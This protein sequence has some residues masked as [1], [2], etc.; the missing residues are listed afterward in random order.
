MRRALHL[1]VSLVPLAFVGACFTYIDGPGAADEPG[2]PLPW[3]LTPDAAVGLASASAL[4]LDARPDDLRAQEPVSRARVLS[5]Q[6]LSEPD[7]PRRGMLLEDL[8]ALSG[9][10]RGV[11]VSQNQDVIVLGD[12]LRG[13]GEAGRIV[14]SLRVM[15]HERAALVD[16]GAP[17]FIARGGRDEVAEP[18]VAPGDFVARPVPA[19][20][21]DG[22]ALQ[23][24][25]TGQGSE[26]VLLD[27]RERREFDGQT[28][29]GE[30]RGGHVPGA[31]HLYFKELLDDDG[32]LLE[33][34]RVAAL[35][36][37]RGVSADDDIVAYCTGGVRSAFV[38]AALLHLGYPNVRNYP[39]SM[40]EW[41]AQD[42][43]LD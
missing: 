2:E 23:A 19:L 20:G 15:G 36:S 32:F 29:Y 34:E 4:V 35:L 18:G 8:D 33:P 7:D 31:V 43:P 30:S 37:A 1:F 3:I 25:L 14:W 5:W 22:P 41:S 11:G 12:P 27:T 39:A 9:V 38:V 42:W 24:A 26:V 6:Q 13:W 28:P 40:W 17:A 16:G 10:L 21:V